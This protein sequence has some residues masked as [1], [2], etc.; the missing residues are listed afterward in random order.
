MGVVLSL[1][2]GV[3]FGTR[4]AVKGDT[5]MSGIGK[6]KVEGTAERDGGEGRKLA[7][8]VVLRL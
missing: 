6:G 1:V 2:T 5:R 8:S 7:G 4:R 3:P